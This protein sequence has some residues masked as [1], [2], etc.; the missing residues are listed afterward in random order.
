MF[1][2][3][4]WKNDKRICVGGVVVVVV[5]VVVMVVVVVVFWGLCH[6]TLTPAK[7]PRNGLS[8]HNIHPPETIMIIIYFT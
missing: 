6:S 7:T 3:Y 4:L 2:D 5:V 8:Q 1:V